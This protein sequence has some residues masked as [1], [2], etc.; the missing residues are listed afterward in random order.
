MSGNSDTQR[1]LGQVLA[2][3]PWLLFE[4]LTFL[5]LLSLILGYQDFDVEL[6][7]FTRA[8][9]V[10]F[11]STAFVGAVHMLAIERN[12]RQPLRCYVAYGFMLLRALL[13]VVLVYWLCV[14][15]L[16]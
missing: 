6:K 8:F 9:F 5:V 1:T 4:A 14:K 11:L 13:I 3:N 2:L 15:G 12:G 16:I 7:L 10:F